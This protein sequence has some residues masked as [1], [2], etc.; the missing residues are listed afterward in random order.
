MPFAS[1]ASAAH[2]RLRL[3]PHD[4]RPPHIHVREGGFFRHG[5]WE[6]ST[7]FVRGAKPRFCV[8]MQAKGRQKGRKAIWTATSCPKGEGYG[9]PES[10]PF[11]ND[12][13]CSV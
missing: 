5:W 2:V 4:I 6:N 9:W 7:R 8:T 13:K 12:I 1:I 11:A 3:R 10:K